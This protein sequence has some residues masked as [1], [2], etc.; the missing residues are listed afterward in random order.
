MEHQ[1]E[2]LIH[3]LED[4]ETDWRGNNN[5]GYIGHNHNGSMH[6]DNANPVYISDIRG[7]DNSLLHICYGS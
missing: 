2:R 5:P 6:R 7:N 3:Y 4:D 1:Q